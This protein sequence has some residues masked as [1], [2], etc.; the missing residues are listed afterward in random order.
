MVLCRFTAKKKNDCQKV[1]GPEMNEKMHS[2][3]GRIVF[4]FQFSRS[5]YI[6]L[7]IQTSDLE[8]KALGR[9]PSE[10]KVNCPPD[11]NK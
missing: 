8:K 3:A 6:T 1:I 11:K 2:S 5:R 10:V 7:P 9:G 4:S